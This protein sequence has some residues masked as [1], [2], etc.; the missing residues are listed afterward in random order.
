[1]KKSKSHKEWHVGDKKYPMGDYYG[2][3]VRAKIGRMR[4]GT[5]MVNVSKKQLGNPP[6]S[7]V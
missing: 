7:V 6:K 5:G 3:G 4:D 2:T 1:M